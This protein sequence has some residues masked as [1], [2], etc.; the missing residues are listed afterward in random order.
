MFPDIFII[1]INVRHYMSET[2]NKIKVKLE[3]RLFFT[4]VYA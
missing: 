3:L 1:Q 4:S 2:A